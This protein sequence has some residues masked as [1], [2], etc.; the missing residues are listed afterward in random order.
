MKKVSLV[1]PN[2][3]DLWRFISI[4]HGVNVSIHHKIHCLT[5]E[6]P[7]A[8]IELAKEEFTAQVFENIYANKQQ[9]E[10]KE[11]TKEKW[12]SMNFSA[13]LLL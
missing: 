12:G 5:A 2:R 4:S 9:A 1:F 11:I 3:E 8:E 7:L 6:F 13:T 10:K